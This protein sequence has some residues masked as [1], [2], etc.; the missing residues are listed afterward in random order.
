MQ[1]QKRRKT[2]SKLL[3]IQIYEVA[4]MFVRYKLSKEAYNNIS[5]VRRELDFYGWEPV[6]S[7]KV[8]YS[9][10]NAPRVKV[11]IDYNGRIYRILPYYGKIKKVTH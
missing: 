7:C 11:K 9:L 4:A 3:S 10:P 2:I 6:D 8:I 5:I 1:K